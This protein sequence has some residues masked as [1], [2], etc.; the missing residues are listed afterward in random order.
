MYTTVH[1]T[2]TDANKSLNVHTIT[3]ALSVIFSL[4]ATACCMSPSPYVAGNPDI[5]TMSGISIPCGRL[6]SLV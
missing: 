1:E 6:P 2:Q 4:A 3:E 5:M